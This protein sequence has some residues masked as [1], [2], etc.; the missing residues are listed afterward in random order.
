MKEI[1][2]NHSEQNELRILENQA[3]IIDLIKDIT[4]DPVSFLGNLQNKNQSFLCNPF[5]RMLNMIHFIS[6]I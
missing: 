5:V 6:L 2:N 3:N 4:L 1:S